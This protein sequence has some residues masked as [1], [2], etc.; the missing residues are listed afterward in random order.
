MERLFFG[1]VGSSYE[2]VDTRWLDTLCF[3]LSW[4]AI[5]QRRM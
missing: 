3:K 1:Y 2:K 4:G 5:T